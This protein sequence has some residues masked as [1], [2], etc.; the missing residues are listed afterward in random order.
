MM[1]RTI[2][3]LALALALAA[4]VEEDGLANAHDT[5]K[6]MKSQGLGADAC[7][8]LAE[9]SIQDVNSAKGT[10]Q[11]FLNTLDTGATCA[12]RGQ[13]EVA[14]AKQSL[15][16]ATNAASHA[17]SA[18]DNASAVVPVITIPSVATLMGMRETCDFIYGSDAV[19]N[20]NAALVTAQVTKTQADA[21]VVSYTTALKA[22]QDAASA[23]AKQ[24][25][26]D[27]KSKLESEWTIASDPT[28]AAT[29]KSS[30]DQAQNILC[31][32]NAKSPCNAPAVPTL[33]KPILS[34]DTQAENC[35]ADRSTP[36][37]CTADM[38]TPINRNK[39]GEIQCMALDGKNC[40]WPGPLVNC[41]ALLKS[42]PPN[43]QPLVCG[44]M[45]QKFYGGSGYNSPGHWCTKSQ[46]QIP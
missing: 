40:L 7:Q 21:Q 15:N 30:W 14:A 36:W 45:H 27:A 4:A 24:C 38:P 16:D 41:E 32:L 31:A 42:P 26:C 20:A 34:A 39:D 1:L 9:S 37:R 44:A 17:K 46:E 11:S 8:A 13:K 18:L 5:I 29:Q 33:V 25:R 6:L 28:N 19:K 10:T 43:I 23:A 22:A 35:I 2:V 12:Q 3:C